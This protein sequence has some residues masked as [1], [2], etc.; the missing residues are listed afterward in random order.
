MFTVKEY[1]KPSSLDEAYTLLQQNKKN[2]ILGGL[3]WLRMGNKAINKG[4]DLSGLEIDKIE[5]TD[6]EFII[7]AMVSLREL[8]VNTEL[9]NKFNG[10]FKEA[11]KHIVGVQFRNLAT[12]GGSIYSRFGF[13]DILTVFLGLD[14]Y[15]VLHGGGKISMQEFIE[16]GYVRDI[17]TKIIIKKTKTKVCY[18]SQRKSETD[19]PVLALATSKNEYGWKISVGA[20]P[21][22]AKIAFESAKLLSLNPNEIEIEK[23]SEML[24]KELKFDSNMRGSKEYRKLIA[25]VLLKRCIDIIEGEEDAN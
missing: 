4:I 11:T 14:S 13:S 9:N 6:D 18:L 5:E 15:V 8:E 2:T 24:V 17:I 21:Q 1:V 16:L 23:A 7:G 12:V 3:L 19:I 25:K 22:K 10:V 20:R